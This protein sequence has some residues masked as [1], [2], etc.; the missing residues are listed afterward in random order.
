[1]CKHG[2]D[3]F[4]TT[5]WGEG[6]I[7]IFSPSVVATVVS[8]PDPHSGL[9]PSLAPLLGGVAANGPSLN[10]PLRMAFSR[11]ELPCARLHTLPRGAQ[12]QGQVSSGTQKPSPFASI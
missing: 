2:Q 11:R 5:S 10:S 12:F 7:E 3:S 8:C 6:G 1:M 9:R 4:V